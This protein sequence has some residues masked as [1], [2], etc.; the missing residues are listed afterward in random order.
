MKITLYTLKVLREFLT[1]PNPTYGLEL[2]KKTG[3]NA[4]ALYP[5]LMRLEQSKWLS[6]EWE[7]LEP[8]ATRTARRY[9]KLTD[10]GRGEAT[11]ALAET[12]QNVDQI[13]LGQ[14]IHFWLDDLATKLDK[15]TEEHKNRST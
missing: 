10:L 15:I 14:R 13:T 8:N 12:K 11:K 2:Y 4:G 6:S 1:N 3:V 5:I 7:T 9:Y